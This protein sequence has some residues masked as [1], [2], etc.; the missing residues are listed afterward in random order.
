MDFESK[1][2]K[3]P[4]Y[5]TI[6]KVE[7]KWKWAILYTISQFKVIRYNRL[8]EKLQPIA[9]RTLSRQ[10]KE[11][12]ADRLVH[13]EQYNEVPPRVE[14]SLTEEGKILIPILELMSEWGKQRLDSQMKE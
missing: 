11:L 1:Y 4:M 13:R 3:C 6:S 10:L 9:H 12:K 2:G 14:Y 7:G 5:Y 8:R